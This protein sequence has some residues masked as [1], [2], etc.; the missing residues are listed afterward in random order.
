MKLYSKI[1]I[2]AMVCVIGLAAGFGLV[3]AMSDKGSDTVAAIYDLYLDSYDWGPVLDK[4]VMQTDYPINAVDRST[5]SVMEHMTV[6][7]YDYN[8]NRQVTACY[9]CDENGQM[10]EEDKSSRFITIEL[11]AYPSLPPYFQQIDENGGK[12]YFGYPDSFDAEIML[13]D[14]A[15][16][17]SVKTEVTTFNISRTANSLKRDIDDFETASFEASDG[18]SYDYALWTPEKNADTLIVFLQGL[19]AGA[20]V[21]RTDAYL[22]VQVFKTEA[23]TSDSFQNMMGG[24]SILVPQC[25]TFWM[26]YSGSAEFGTDGLISH[27]NTSYYTQSLHELILS[28]K[29][30]TKADKVIL[31]GTSNGGFMC[32]VMG[33]NYGSE[34]DGY[35]MMSES[36]MDY[37]L[38]D[39]D[40]QKL[41]Q[42]PMYFLYSMDDDVEPVDQQEILTIDRL[43]A[44][45][46]ANIH[47]FEADGIFDQSGMYETDD[48]AYRYSGH[49]TPIAF[50]NDW[51][52]CNEAD[53]CGMT[54][55]Q[56]MASIAQ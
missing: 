17:T 1:M 4:I 43:R 11:A 27:D 31:I 52:Y 25:P 14:S 6:D 16:L 32:M 56:W 48:G 29:D 49:F 34:Y 19:T 2:G 53:G 41:A 33:L 21:S 26:D 45:G 22:P 24:A 8:T 38:S 40:I 23:M 15:A 9:L 36:M 44:A 50:F 55:W 28:V 18:V 35:L 42:C 20:G 10:I 39:D 37:C 30:Q 54:A 51:D 3:R 7:G 12:Y 46:A 13:S 47:A 5:F